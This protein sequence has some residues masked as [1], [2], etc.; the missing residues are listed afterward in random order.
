MFK[1]LTTAKFKAGR[2]GDGLVSFVSRNARKLSNGGIGGPGGD[3]YVEG[4]TNLYDLS[5]IKRDQVFKAA[6]GGIGGDNN[7]S[8]K[9]GEDMILKVPLATNIY[10]LNH[11][12][13][14]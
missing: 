6:D 3:F 1:D 7:M 10:N 4:T 11:E 13:W 14:K 2:G 8:G 5:F 12:L 9:D